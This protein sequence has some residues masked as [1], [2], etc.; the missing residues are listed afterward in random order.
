MKYKVGDKVRLSNDVYL[1]RSNGL[2]SNVANTVQTITR[3]ISK[4]SINKIGY[5][6]FI[7][8]NKGYWNVRECQIVGLARI[9]S[10]KNLIQNDLVEIVQIMKDIE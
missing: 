7:N 1:I 9:N 2:P 6:E 4:S 3:V 5:Y 8:S 10:W